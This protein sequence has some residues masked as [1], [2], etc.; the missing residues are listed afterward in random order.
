MKTH[1]PKFLICCLFCLL[2]GVPLHAQQMIVNPM[3]FLDKLPVNS[4]FNLY[5]DRQGFFWLGTAYG[6]ERYDGYDIQPF[7]NNYKNPHKL[8]HNDIRCFAEDD[9]YLW[10]G[11]VQGINLVDKST[12][13]IT[14]F[15]DSALQTREIRDLICDQ[16]GNI[17]VAAGKKLFRCNARLGVLKEY[18][19]AN[20]PNTFFEDR[21]G[22]LWFLTWNGDILKY[23]DRDD[24]F[25]QYAHMDNSNPY[26]MIQDHQ[27]RYWIATWGQGIWRFDP[28]SP[29][30]KK[31]LQRQS[32]VNPIRHSPEQVFFDIV[33]DDMY[34]YL[35][36]L[37][38]FRLYVFRI[39]EQN[40]LEEVNINAIK[41][42]NNPIDQYKTYSRIIKDQSG[43]L[44]LGAYDQGYTI[45]FE[46]AEIINHT[47]E[48][49]KK[50]L[51]VDANVLYFNKDSK[52]TIWFDQSR[53]GLCLFDEQTGKITYGNNADALYSLVVTSIV[54]SQKEDVV[55]LGG[56]NDFS[57]HIWKATKEQMHISILEEY[58][59]KEVVA[60]PGSITQLV[61]DDHGNIWIGTT[62]RL[63]FKQ[64]GSKKI[65]ELSF[66]I[67]HIS[68]MSKDSKGN[69]WIASRDAIY[70]MAY[71]NKP[72]LLK[73]YPK[74]S[75]PLSDAPIVNI[76]ANA[77][78]VWFSTSLGRLLRF[79]SSEEKM[80]DE[81]EACGLT[82]DN[83]LKILLYKD[84][85]WIVCDKYIIR[86][87]PATKE[88]TAYFV[89][90]PNIFVSSFR[91]SA[92]F[93]DEEGCLY[94][95][96][97]NGFIKILPDRQNTNNKR[98]GQ[99]LITDV[100]SDNR[101]VL[102]SPAGSETG[103][104]VHKITLSPETR[105]IE[106]LFSALSYTSGRRIKYAYQLEGA[107]KKW[108]YIDNGKHSAFYNYLGK[109][110]YTFRLKATD[111]Y[112]NWMEEE[113]Q[114]LIRRL[115]AWYET[116]YAYSFYTLFIVC[117]ICLLFYAYTKRME[118]KNKLKLQ[119]ELTQI[120]LNYFTNI[121]HE[122]LTPLTIISCV[123]DDLEENKES[124][125]RQ[126]EILRSNANR[127]KRLLQ[128]ILD[129]RKVESRKME[130]SASKSNLSSFVSGI[131]ASN[132]QSLAHQKSI[133]LSTRIDDGI[134]GYM[135]IDKFDK[136]LFNLLSNAIKYTPEHKK[137]NVSLSAIY[138]EGCR[139]LV[140]NVEDEG[141]GIAEKDIKHIFTKFYN[142]KN[143][144]GCQSNGI[145]LS[146]TK[147]LVTLH[148]GTIEVS[149]EPGKGSV[150]T[151]EIPIDREVYSEREIA[152]SSLLTVQEEETDTFIPDEKPC[153]LFID[154]N[155]DLRELIQHILS[156][157]YQ[158]FIA[159][160]ALQGLELL[161]NTPVDIIICDIMMPQMNGLEF[162]QQIKGDIQ[163][164][165]IPIIMLTAKNAVDDQIECYKAGAE[166]YIAKPFEMKILQARIDNLLQSREQSRQSFRS[167]MEINIS[168][169]NYQTSDEEFLNNAM[170]CVERHIQESEFDT[171]QMANEL[172]ISRSTL[173]RK[174]KVISGCT[175]LEFIRN[176]KLKYACALLKKKT[177]SISEVAYA[178]GFSSPKYF[179]KC[180]KEEFGM[181]PTEYQSQ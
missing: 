137:I 123:A 97:H 152:E 58:D 20:D 160:N 98:T 143:H 86:H 25:M 180:F 104:S 95:G 37:S 44:W 100:K 157:K 53:Y 8:T 168:N 103:N 80:T 158:I 142:N 127:L 163:T 28:S 29:D 88:N 155:K 12:Y 45:T 55:W 112:G 56:R 49:I 85:I 181:T 30:R 57:S 108:T 125:E 91:H 118:K 150:F 148:H 111:P 27:G 5:Q 132:F 72:I 47:M 138:K 129:F 68:D 109:G 110:E 161:K 122:L 89:N 156:K 39:N 18:T 48:N 36:A 65:A 52:G 171:V 21:N 135:D 62:S 173:S 126:V 179:T 136:I 92:A 99:V 117:I 130:I 66:D 102:F 3:P 35:W 128:Q 41:D 84:K 71:E 51:G 82:G 115:P 113:Q 15:P 76:C 87:H 83:I 177:I 133:S 9:N 59:L 141:I 70:Q 106:I 166:S 146:L 75:M 69:V 74:E 22:D 78:D 159:E 31:I 107:D 63:F 153:I 114:L 43:N 149:S 64:A 11:T 4:I 73:H 134:W 170:Q 6:L 174:C 54:P 14:S 1:I 151:V 81:T 38:H 7:I 23:N 34:G 46:K 17:W 139:F 77:R 178:T 140:L 24:S 90:D 145:G 169:L 175:P 119:E 32:I 101:S 124:S 79:D 96:G 13:Q 172:H 10:V 16:K 154:D 121:S 120:K 94:A 26:R 105:N 164:N 19:L 147:E 33:Q 131:V 116:W 42:I 60:D 93:V 67:S 165:H 2:S 50:R 176:I 40:E 144:P 162:C 167:K 61:E